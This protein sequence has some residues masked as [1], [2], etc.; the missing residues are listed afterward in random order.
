VERAVQTIVEQLS[1]ELGR[2]VLVDDASLRLVAFSPLFGTEDQ[3]RR[4]AILTRQTPRS[5]R[6]LLF[7][8]GIATAHGAVR[9]PARID[10]GLESRVCVPIRCAATLFG[11]LWLI[12]TDES[13]SDD[14]LAVAE[15]A[16][17]EIGAKIYRDRERDRPQR[18]R[19][20]QLLESL[21]GDDAVAASEAARQLA[22]M[23][24]LVPGAPVAAVVATVG[25]GLGEEL[26][27]AHAAD[28]SLAL[29]QVREALPFRHALTLMRA[30]HGIV[31]LA[32]DPMIRHH[33]GVAALARRLQES[34]VDSCGATMERHI[35]VGYSEERELLEDARIAY[36]HAQRASRVARRVPEHG[37]VAGWPQLGAYRTLVEVA[38][39][40]RDAQILH[41]GLS[42]LMETP[43][44]ESLV[45]TLETYFD[46]ACDAKATAE[47]LFLHRAS[48]YYR[49]QRIEEAAGVSLKSGDDRLALHLGLK[50]AWLLGIH[51]GQRTPA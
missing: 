32:V 48:L 23:D 29:D 19:E 38:D 18:E 35:A 2:S 49:L 24:L 11:Y 14:E 26:L 16:A 6:D 40:G 10:L 42:R 36:V 46:H 22:G 47:A 7:G 34:L 50:L 5:I 13:M 43:G 37:P 12:D 9:T 3:V 33:G 27:C 45:T 28:L 41:P 30:H 4:T 1:E 8:E 20:Q 39:S 21:L 51:P 15:H 17:G 31:L 25:H 44:S